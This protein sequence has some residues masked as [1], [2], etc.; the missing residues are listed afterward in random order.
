MTNSQKDLLISIHNQYAVQIV[1]GQK[2]VELRRR[3][4]L[5]TKRDKKKIFIYACAP[6][7][8]IIGYCDLK[9]VKKMPLKKLWNIANKCAMIDRGSFYKYFKNC[10]FGFALYLE[11]PVKYAKPIDLRQV[12]GQNQTPPQSY[13][14]ICQPVRLVA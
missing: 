9:I 12:F 13:R 3:F 7:S 6:A 14:Y 8:Q 2:T 1:Q 11:N 10:D 5:F 4:P